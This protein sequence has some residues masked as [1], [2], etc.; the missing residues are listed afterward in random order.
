MHKNCFLSRTPSSSLFSTHFTTPRQ[1]QSPYYTTSPQSFPSIWATCSLLMFRICLS[2]NSP[3]LLKPR[4]NLSYIRYFH[5]TSFSSSLNRST[6]KPAAFAEAIQDGTNHED[7]PTSEA[8]VAI[9]SSPRITTTQDQQDACPTKQAIENVTPP[10]SQF[11]QSSND[12]APKKDISDRQKALKESAATEKAT[13]E[14]LAQPK[15]PYNR[16]SLTEEEK[17]ARPRKTWTKRSEEE[18]LKLKEERLARKGRPPGRVP[19]DKSPERHSP[20]KPNEKDL[21]AKAKRLIQ[22]GKNVITNGEKLIRLGNGLTGEEDR[23]TQER[24]KR[25]GEMLLRMREEELIFK[26]KEKLIKFGNRLIQNGEN[27]IRTTETFTQKQ[28]NSISKEK[29]P[30]KIKRRKSPPRFWDHLLKTENG[31]VNV[32]LTGEE[33]VQ[34]GKRLIQNGE[35]SI[36]DIIF[37][38]RAL[39]VIRNTQIAIRDS[40]TVIRSIEKLIRNIKIPVKVRSGRPKPLVRS[41]LGV[42]RGLVSINPGTRSDKTRV[43]VVGNE[44]CGKFSFLFF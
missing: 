4:P 23:N 18:V 24:N 11:G 32:I 39:L 33:L 3:A 43:N 34:Q 14:E 36:R 12:L 13:E 2:C 35:T 41:K 16:K 9:K 40:K 8:T 1:H 6:P 28:F 5:C 25:I 17:L 22:N 42:K 44:L 29:S 30:A 20:L 37:R 31:K 38:N 26:K 15:R 10:R 21:R 19:K 7:H 27:L